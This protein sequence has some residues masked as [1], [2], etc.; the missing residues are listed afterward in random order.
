MCRQNKVKLLVIFRRNTLNMVVYLMYRSVLYMFVGIEKL[1]YMS[2]NNNLNT[3][4]QLLQWSYCCC[5]L[6]LWYLRF[7]WH[8]L[9]LFSGFKNECYCTTCKFCSRKEMK[10][11]SNFDLF[12]FL[13]VQI[14]SFS[15]PESMSTCPKVT[16][17]LK[18]PADKINISFKRA[19][20]DVHV[21]IYI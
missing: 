7:I 5:C 6:R 16:H 10:Y 11:Y 3:Y 18:R 8:C 13:S 21:A 17:C 2:D 1:S 4:W 14:N 20:W 12:C 15:N 19:I 9:T